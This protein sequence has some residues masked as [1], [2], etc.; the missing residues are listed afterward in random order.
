MIRGLPSLRVQFT[1]IMLVASTAFAL[2]VLPVGYLATRAALE[3]RSLGTAED[4]LRAHARNVADLVLVEDTLSLR[5][6]VKGLADANPTWRGVFVLDGRGGL[7][8]RFPRARAE[9]PLAALADTGATGVVTLTPTHDRVAVVE[10]TLVDP[11]IGVLRAV[12]DLSRDHAAAMATTRRLGLAVGF[13]TLVGVALAFLLG[14]SLTRDLDAITERVERFGRGDLD[15]RAPERV[16]S[17]E[18]AV[19]AHRFNE[20]ADRLVE[21]RERLVRQQEQLIQVERLAALGTFAAG[22]AHEVVNPLAGVAGCVRRLGRADL[23]EERR[24][25][26]TA[27][28]L[29][30]LRRATDVLRNLL[31]FARAEPR[32]PQ[33]AELSDLLRRTVDLA[34]QGC[35]RSV[36][37]AEGPPVAVHWP[38]AQVEQVLTN[39]VLNAVQA[40][41][42]EVEVRWE[43]EGDRIRIAILDD[44]PGIPPSLRTRVFEPFFTT[45]KAGGGTGLGLSVS[46]SLVEALGGRLW[47]DD[48]P[49]GRGGLCARLELPRRT[50]GVTPDAS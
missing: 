9:D 21:A 2:A 10:A 46:R 33:P 44:G 16:S 20:M 5:E 12:V 36:R 40:A 27:M 22:T 29:D 50:P 14:R 30:G 48:R 4:Q 28:A 23:P 26:Y 8:A 47:L 1:A 41:T 3:R 15:A 42:S 11:R 25:R 34:C 37:V 19:L 7:L 38:V 32:P 39:L 31:T 17:T 13:L 18:V 24:D 49:D 45:R 43:E 6:Y 35:G